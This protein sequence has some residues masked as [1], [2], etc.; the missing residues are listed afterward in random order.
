VTGPAE[1]GPYRVVS[2]LGVG[3]A[4]QVFCVEDALGRRLAL[5]LL[6]NREAPERF[7]REGEV[8]ANLTHSGI[9]R[10]HGRGVSDGRPYLVYELIDGDDLEAS[11]ER[12]SREQLLRI[13][14]EVALA[15]GYAHGQGVVHRDVKPANVLIDRA[16]KPHVADFGLAHA[17]G[18][19][20]L[21]RSG[22]M[23]GTPRYMAPEQAAG[24]RERYGPATDVWALG[25]LLY[26]VL[27]GVE[28]FQGETLVQLVGQLTTAEP[29][30]PRSHD[31]SI[32]P[33]LVEVCL[34]ALSKD[35]DDR[36]PDGDAFAADLERA[37]AGDAVEGRL[38]RGMHRWLALAAGAA[39]LA[40]GGLGATLRARARTPTPVE[41]ATHAPAEEPEPAAELAALERRLDE[42]LTELARDPAAGARALA[43]L[44]SDASLDPELSR[45]LWRAGLAT[46]AADPSPEAVLPRLPLLREL[47]QLSP[48]TRD[49]V[50]ANAEAAAQSVLAAVEVLL[51]RGSAAR[52]AGEE[53]RS[54]ELLGE[55]CDALQQLADGRLRVE[56]PRSGVRVQDCLLGLFLF[57]HVDPADYWRAILAGV[58]LD[59]PSF[60]SY[61]KPQGGLSPEGRPWGPQPKAPW[62]RFLELRIQNVEERSPGRQAQLERALLEPERWAGEPWSLGPRQWAAAA[63]YVAPWSRSQEVRREL[64]ERALKLDPQEPEVHR[65]LAELYRDQ[66]DLHR[67]RETIANGIACFRAQYEGNMYRR[68]LLAKLLEQQVKLL[69][70]LEE[71]EAARTSWRELRSVGP[72]EA[73]ALREHA[74]WL[75]TAD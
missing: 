7:E 73:A 37:L 16:G 47:A 41:A 42:A 9:V 6:S 19:E 11:F 58:E 43:R 17:V 66:G 38:G 64:L 57:Q 29:A 14:R 49:P 39:L 50:D 5:K 25:V 48:A 56:D 63:A 70:R 8:T 26:R 31:P 54:R 72:N 4:R 51:E 74:P 45:E 71:R 55:A 67:S 75:N 46:L 23:L 13:T 12:L 30:D 22:V 61:L 33:E 15:L 27:T 10:V 53:Q 18:L 32:S 69:V 62:E 3:A 40:A 2:R 36:Y 68:W 21:T 34:R 24:A 44:R 60:H 20:R 59:L 1:I 35:P 65:R 52:V 28:P